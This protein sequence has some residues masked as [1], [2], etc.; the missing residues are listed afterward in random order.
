[1]ALRDYLIG[2]VAQDCADGLLDR[3]EA[4]RRLGL[5]GLGTGAA[6]AALAGCAPGPTE[7]TP[8]GSGSPVTGPGTAGPGTAPAARTR[9]V[10][11]V[12]FAGPS[13]E[14]QAAWAAPAADGPRG[15][16]VLVIHENRGLTPHFHDVAGRLAGAGHAALAVDLLSSEGG[17]AALTDPAQ[18]P[19][20]LSQAAPEQLRAQL[21]AGLDELARRAPGARLGAVG[22]CF[23]GG[24]V[25]SLLQAGE[26]RLAAAA[27]FYGPVPDPVDFSKARAA[28]LGVFGELDTRV[29]AGRERAAA[30]LTA[31]KLEHDIKTYAGADHAFFNDTGPRYNPT[32]AADAWRDLLDWFG[33]HLA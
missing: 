20:L 11:V 13:G 5:M 14:L 27:P 4:L 30:A 29:N 28:V 15:G 32:A 3:R 24:M 22:F 17:T 19:T 7:G 10:E 2:E 8:A 23:G 1:M 33:R 16:A 31:A 25:W 21:G 9:P 26:A 12:R 18:A 6:V